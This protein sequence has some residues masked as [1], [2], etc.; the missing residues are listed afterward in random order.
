MAAIAR[1]S[2]Y[3]HLQRCVALGR[4]H[5][6]RS[7]RNYNNYALDTVCSVCLRPWC[8]DNAEYDETVGQKQ[9][10]EVGAAAAKVGIRSYLLEWG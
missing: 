9:T 1:G 3:R 5:R 2:S 7:S 4:P 10:V 6:V 8:D